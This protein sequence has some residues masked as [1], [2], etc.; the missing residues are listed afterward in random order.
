MELLLLAKAT[1]DESRR[2]RRSTAPGRQEMSL[3]LMHDAVEFGVV[4]VANKV[5]AGIPRDFSS[6]GGEIAQAQKAAGVS[7]P[8]ELPSLKRIGRLSD[9]RVALKHKGNLP[10]LVT[11]TEFDAV[12]FDYLSDLSRAF[13]DLE[14]DELSE[15][16]LVKTA[17]I[18]QFLKE[19]ERL[20][21]AGQPGRAMCRAADARDAA[22]EMLRGVL[23]WPGMDITYDSNPPVPP[24]M[25]A[26]L[27]TLDRRFAF[28]QYYVESGLLALHP[29]ERGYLDSLLPTK[30]GNSYTFRTR[31]DSPEI[32]ARCV[33]LAA[34]FAVA[35]D[36]YAADSGLDQSIPP[37]APPDFAERFHPAP[38]V[39]RVIV[40]EAE[41]VPEKP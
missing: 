2:L 5:G 37:G 20:L 13:F 23:G 38:N 33:R 24:Q 35:V 15:A 25:K 4:A 7:T 6:I 36:S 28:T 32:A 22:R 9:A 30:S 39:E 11:L 27:D 17:A 8:K 29:S 12:A 34:R 10:A 19:A 21:A 41:G 1:L 16:D 3:L 40:M 26:R 31:E 18:R 14:F